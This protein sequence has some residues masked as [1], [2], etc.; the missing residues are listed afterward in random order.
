MYAGY[1]SV[2]QLH[3]IVRSS[4]PKVF[5]KKSV[6]GNFAK[7]TGKYLCQ[8]HPPNACKFIKK[9]SL[10]Q[11]LSCEFYEI[12]K[13]TFFYRTPP[14]TV[15]GLSVPAINHMKIKIPY[16]RHHKET[17]HEKR[18]TKNTFL[19]LPISSAVQLYFSITAQKIKFSI[20]DFFGIHIY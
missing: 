9:D 19:I 12:S 6:L 15:S 16:L 5:C 4:R 14:A 2:I 11:V 18:S 10:V 20:K 1:A 7:F 13:N 8:R 17:L 3:Q